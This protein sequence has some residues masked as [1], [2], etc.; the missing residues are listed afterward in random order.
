MARTST[1]S[2]LRALE[3]RLP[4]DA[5]EI[6]LIVH[7]VIDPIPEL[8]DPERDAI[9]AERKA[10]ACDAAAKHAKRTGTVGRIIW[11]RRA[12]DGIGDFEL[13]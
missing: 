7:D 13:L 3:Q 5:P 2:R 8:P 6:V 11:D 1:W 4:P 12:A 9:R 10:A